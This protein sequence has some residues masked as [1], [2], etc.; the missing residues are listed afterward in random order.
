[1]VFIA[2]GF[3]YRCC[4]SHNEGGKSD[5]KLGQIRLVRAVCRTFGSAFHRL[6]VFSFPFPPI[7]TIWPLRTTLYH[8]LPV[9]PWLSIPKLKVGWVL[10]YRLAKIRGLVVNQSYDH[11]MLSLLP[12]FLRHS[13]A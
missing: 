3:Q 8:I 2:G 1:M 9:S 5:A 10:K 11:K 12:G 7:Q 6:L 4:Y 13:F